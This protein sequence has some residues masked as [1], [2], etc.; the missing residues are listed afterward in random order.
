MSRK[1]AKDL[2]LGVG[3]SAGANFIGSILQIDKTKR[4]V[5]TVF[6]MIIKNI[7]QLNLQM[8]LMKILSLYLIK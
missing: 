6:P 3:I 5:V 8:T 7:F 4:P 2:G 1:L